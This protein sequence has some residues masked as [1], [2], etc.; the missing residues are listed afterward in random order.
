MNTLAKTR[1][2]PSGAFAGEQLKVLRNTYA[3]LSATLLFSAMTTGISMA[4]N[5]GHP[6]ILITLGAYFGLLFGIHKCQNSHWGIA[7]VFAL[8]GFMGITLGP[9]LNMYLTMA[10]GGQ[11]IMLSLGLTGVTF[12]SLTAYALVTQKDFSNWRTTLTVGIMVAF[13][14]SLAGIFFQIP[15]LSLS[16]SV[17]FML[18]MSG[19]ILY[20]TSNIIHGGEHNYI[21]ATVTL[22]ISIYNMFLSLLH[23]LG[24]LNNN[25]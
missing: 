15:A 20:E 5:F 3:L 24:F 2:L 6:G 9:I 18:L 12:V 14:A 7:L 16:V 4:M 8:T 17:M 25:D 13:L 10:N 22:Y 11:I 23:V 1:S 21:L 19:L